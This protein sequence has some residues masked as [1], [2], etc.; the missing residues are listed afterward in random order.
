MENG[1]MEWGYWGAPIVRIIEMMAAPLDPSGLSPADGRRIT[2]ETAIARNEGYDL[3]HRPTRR[4][5][6]RMWIATPTATGN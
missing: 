3:R 4:E 5:S 1:W 6:I 2:P